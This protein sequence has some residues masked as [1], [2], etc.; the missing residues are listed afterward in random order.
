MILISASIIL[1]I[2][3]VGIGFNSGVA[4]PADWTMYRNNLTH[5][6]VATDVLPPPLSL[7]WKVTFGGSVISSPAI[8]GSRLY[9]GAQ[10]P[11][12]KL[13]AIDV[14]TGNI[15]WSFDD[16]VA[17]IPTTLGWDSSPAV[18]TV[19]GKTVIFAGNNNFKLYAIQ[20]NGATAVKLWDTTALIGVAVKSSPALTNVA[21]T[22]VVIFGTEGA[23][24]YALVAATGGSIQ[25]GW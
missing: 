25:V 20:D 5:T 7:K 12:N 23:G 19:N 4:S 1:A 11:D 2:L 17:G 15:I 18:G 6:G 8:F 13:Y 10:A 3:L 24:V 22:D 21:G 9:V 14:A 16:P